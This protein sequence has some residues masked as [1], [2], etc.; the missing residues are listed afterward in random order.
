MHNQQLVSGFH[1]LTPDTI[2]NLIEKSLGKPCTNLCR[3]LNSYINR[4]Y[5]L[6]LDTG[7]AVIAKFYRPNRWSRQALQEELDFLLKLT[8]LEIPVIPPLTLADQQTLGCH[9]DIY[10]A[11][12]PKKSGRSSDE[13]TDDQWEEIGRLLGRV[14]AVSA[15]QSAS[16]RIVM[17]PN[18]STR[19]HIEY[20][21]HGGFIPH[22]LADHYQEVTNSLLATIEPRFADQETILI[23]GDCHFSNIIHRPGESF[24]LIDFDDMA[25]GPPVQDLWML[26]PGYAQDSRAEIEI[27]LEGYEIFRPFD[28]RSL[29]LIEPLR[30]MRYI[31]YSA[32]CAHQAADSTSSRLEPDW[33]TAEYW[34]REIRD[35]QEQTQRIKEL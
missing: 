34:Q 7:E 17:T 2:I 33:G 14:H 12:F 25:T 18:Q 24:Y 26:L 16:N 3:P 10:Y 20:L 19:H 27:F 9:N 23:H 22:D 15:T 28:R 5:E 13:F 6:E 35:L 30:A 29:K 11:V 21:M 1:N 32:W 31:H 4:V 8:G